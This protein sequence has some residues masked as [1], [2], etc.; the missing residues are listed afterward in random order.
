[1]AVVGVC[2]LIHSLMRKSHLKFSS[3]SS[4]SSGFSLTNSFN[5]VIR[6][7]PPFLLFSSFRVD[8]TILFWFSGLLLFLIIL[9][10]H[11]SCFSC[12]TTRYGVFRNPSLSAIASV[13]SISI[14]QLFCLHVSKK[15]HHLPHTFLRVAWFADCTNLCKLTSSW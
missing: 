2:C 14:M 9:H 1:M 13:L 7:L 10:K 6:L 4:Y 12:C 11:R 15:I 8:S 3:V 5:F